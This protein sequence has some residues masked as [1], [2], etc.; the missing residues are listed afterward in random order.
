MFPFVFDIPVEHTSFS[1]KSRIEYISC[2][3]IEKP[4]F[5]V[6]LTKGDKVRQHSKET[7]TTVEVFEHITPFSPEL[8]YS[9]NIQDINIPLIAK[10]SF[11]VKAKIK[12]VSKF[13]PNPFLG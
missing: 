9:E 5:C 3:T 7:T 4:N 13:S 2:T 8:E 11:S 6:A 12:S 10:K 1:Q